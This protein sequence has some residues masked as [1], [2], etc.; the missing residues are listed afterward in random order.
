MKYF[1]CIII[2]FCSVL[3]SKAQFPEENI[4]PLLE[5]YFE[6]KYDGVGK[7][8]IKHSL[9]RKTELKS[10]NSSRYGIEKVEVSGT[11]VLIEKNKKK[12]VYSFVGIIKRNYEIEPTKLIVVR[13]KVFSSLKP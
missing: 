13:M 4:N 8:Y 9:N 11:L 3:V 10:V 6:M 7:R 1:L 12:T 2:M 5:S